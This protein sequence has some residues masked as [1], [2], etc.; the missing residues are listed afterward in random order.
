MFEREAMIRRRFSTFPVPIRACPVH[1]GGG[2]T[3]NR[4]LAGHVPGRTSRWR[5]CSC[6]T[7]GGAPMPIRA[8]WPWLGGDPPSRH[9]SIGIGADGDGQPILPSA[10]GSLPAS[11]PVREGQTASRS[12]ASPVLVDDAGQP[13]GH[14]AGQPVLH[15]LE[16]ALNGRPKGGRVSERPA[17][18]AEGAIMA[19]GAAAVDARWL[20]RGRIPSGPGVA[21]Y[22]V[23]SNAAGSQAAPALRVTPLDVFSCYE[24]LWPG[25][26]PRTPARHSAGQQGGRP[27]WSVHGSASG[28][29]RRGCRPATTVSRPARRCQTARRLAGR[30][31][32]APPPRSGARHPP[33]PAIPCG[34]ATGTPLG[35]TGINPAR[36]PEGAVNPG[37]RR[38]W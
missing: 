13:D 23:S 21:G 20:E 38:F 1:F 10:A 25:G 9:A 2:R 36:A 3:R 37:R 19:C 31:A 8:P 7:T 18:C 34:N 29:T 22:P 24:N 33:G 32:G 4:G 30:P 6:A 16:A 17:P 11:D 14:A 27:T 15:H 26:I 28:A 12:G 35:C 5:C